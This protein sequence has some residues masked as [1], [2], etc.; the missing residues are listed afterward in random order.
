MRLELARLVSSLLHGARAMLQLVLNFLAFK[1]KKYTADDRFHGNG[2]Y[3]KILTKKEPIRT[4][5]FPL[6]Y[7]NKQLKTGPEGNSEFCFPRISMFPE[8]KQNSLFPKGP[9]IK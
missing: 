8:T 9:V 1:N 4:L 3:G 5:R 7:N 6:P 2:V